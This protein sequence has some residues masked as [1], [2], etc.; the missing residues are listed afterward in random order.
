MRAGK[1][2]MEILVLLIIA[3]LAVLLIGPVIGITVG[4]LGVNLGE[5]VKV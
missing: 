5:P 2:T 4:L 1:T 3:V